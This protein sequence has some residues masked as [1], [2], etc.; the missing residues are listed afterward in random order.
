MD[1]LSF[2]TDTVPIREIW[3]EIEEYVSCLFEGY[4]PSSDDLNFLTELPGPDTPESAVADLL[5]LHVEH[6]TSPIMQAA[7]HVS[8]TCLLQGNQAVQQ[9]ARQF[10]EDTE[11]IS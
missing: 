1:V 8:A 10:L 11:H 7:W 3:A 4:P 6:P 2:L 9:A 5:M